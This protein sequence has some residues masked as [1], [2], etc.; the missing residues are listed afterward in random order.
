MQYPQYDLRQETVELH[1]VLPIQNLSS[2]L[3]DAS[4]LPNCPSVPVRMSNADQNRPDPEN[5]TNRPSA[6]DPERTNQPPPSAM[7]PEEFSLCCRDADI[8]QP[9]SVSLRAFKTFAAS[10]PS[11]EQEANTKPEGLTKEQQLSVLKLVCVTLCTRP[12]ESSSKIFKS[13]RNLCKKIRFFERSDTVTDILLPLLTTGSES[14]SARDYLVEGCMPLATKGNENW[15][16]VLMS[17]KHPGPKTIT[18]TQDTY[19]Y[20]ATVAKD[21]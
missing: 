10:C 13:L 16:R 9:S 18:T 6:D 5:S 20:S 12:L 21:S 19:C 14:K 1:T 3:P 7:T 8:N 2:S 11:P 17:L 4:V 15:I